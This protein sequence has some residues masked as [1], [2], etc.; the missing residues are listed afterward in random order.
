MR[1]SVGSDGAEDSNI[2][3]KEFMRLH[4]DKNQ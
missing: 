3:P 1:G 4:K 2:L